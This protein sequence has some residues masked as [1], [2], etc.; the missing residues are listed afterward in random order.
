MYMLA[1]W[2]GTMISLYALFK[3]VF[4]FIV[5][6]SYEE[7]NLDLLDRFCISIAF[8]I[9]SLCMLYIFYLRISNL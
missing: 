5:Y 6:L 8:G 1:I 9:S 2:V 7:K 4:E 3:G